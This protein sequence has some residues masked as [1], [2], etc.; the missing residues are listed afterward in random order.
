MKASQLFLVEHHLKAL[1]GENFTQRQL[2]VSTVIWF[3]HFTLDTVKAV[4]VMILLRTTQSG[5][6]AFISKSDLKVVD[7][8]PQNC[9]FAVGCTLNLYLCFYFT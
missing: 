7:L 9:D 5:N 1:L 8:K 3:V 6:F 4:F 2:F